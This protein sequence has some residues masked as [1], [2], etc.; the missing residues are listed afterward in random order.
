MNITKYSMKE[1]EDKKDAIKSGG[2]KY[3]M[4]AAIK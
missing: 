2:I 1:F 4:H 3:P